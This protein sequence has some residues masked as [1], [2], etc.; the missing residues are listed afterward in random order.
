ME[1]AQRQDTKMIPGLK[2]KSYETRLNN[3]NLYSSE[4]RLRSDLIQVF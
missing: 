3:L 4:K 2:N 1:S